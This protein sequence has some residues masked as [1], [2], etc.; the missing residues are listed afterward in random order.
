LQDSQ[1]AS[2][3]KGADMIEPQPH[4]CLTPGQNSE[5]GSCAVSVS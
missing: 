5:H 1:P 4:H 2:A 3:G